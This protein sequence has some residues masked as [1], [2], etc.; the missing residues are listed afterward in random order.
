MS[1]EVIHKNPLDKRRIKMSG[2]YYTEFGKIKEVDATS[3][4]GWVRLLSES[5]QQINMKKVYS[6]WAVVAQKA[7]KLIGS[8]V[9]YETGAS[10]SPMEYFRDIIPDDEMFGVF[11]GIPKDAGPNAVQ[12]IITHKI[13]SE[14]LWFTLQ[15]RNDQTEALEAQI[16]AMTVE[17]QQQAEVA[18]GQIDRQIQDFLTNPMRAFM[19]AGQAVNPTAKY[20][21]KIDVDFALRL[22]L[23]VTKL[24]RINVEVIERRGTGN[25]LV[26]RLPD[27]DN[28]ECTLGIAQSTH[29]RTHGEWAVVHVENH[30]ENWFNIQNMKRFR[31][32]KNQRQPIDYFIEK[33]FEMFGVALFG[34]DYQPAKPAQ[35]PANF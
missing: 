25:K 32:L 13:R 8:P 26:C 10:S 33:H 6:S 30:I 12:H 27:Y 7:T 2:A 15:Q 28:Y 21:K 18:A 5:G 29:N 31:D 19:I 1:E 23:D 17:Q 24:K 20:P 4:P 34:K 16:E 22:G 3:A 14:R 11:D 9:I 35:L